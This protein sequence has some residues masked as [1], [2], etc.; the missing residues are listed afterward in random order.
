MTR[1]K[2][3]IHPILADI[4]HPKKKAAV[5]LDWKPNKINFALKS[6]KSVFK[7]AATFA[8]VGL[9]FG[10]SLYGAHLWNFK[11]EAYQSISSI[12]ENFKNAGENMMSLEPASASASLSNIDLQLKN[13]NQQASFLGMVPVLKE[14][15]EV[16]S[17][18]QELTGTIILLNND[19]AEIKGKGFSFIFNS[20]GANDGK[21]LSL[22]TDAHSNLQKLSVIATS[23]RNR[24]LKYKS[25]PDDMNSQYFELNNDLVKAADGLASVINVLGKSGENHFVVIFENPSEIRPGGGFVG[26]YADLT[27]EGGSIKNIDVNDIYYPDRFSDLKIKPPKQLQTVTT[28]WGARDA[29]W[30]FNFPTSA[31]KIIEFLEGSNIYKD[32]N[33]K[34]DGVI[35]VNVELMEDILKIVG[36]IEVPGYGLT[37]NNENFLSEV[38]REVE[39][40]RDKK[41]GQ[42]P[43]KVLSV[44]MPI[45]LE[46]L[47]GLDDARKA[48]FFDDLLARVKNKDVKFYFKDKD[49]QNIAVQSNV[50]GEV[51]DLPSNFKGDYLAVVNTNVASGKSDVFIDQAIK[52]SSR[53][54]ES[55]LVTNDLTVSRSHR[56]QDEKDWWYR[57]T[58][59]NFIKIFTPPDAVLRTMS[60]NTSKDIKAP[61]DYVKKGY[62]ID[63]D[64]SLIEDTDEYLSG[65]KT[66]VY[67]ESG[68]NVFATWFNVAAAET[69]DLSLSYDNSDKLSLAEGS[70][71]EFVLDKQS[72]VLSKFDYIL[73]A[74][75]GFKW[76]EV[77]DFIFHYRTDDMPT[78]LVID[79][80]LQKI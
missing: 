70:T 73:E 20:D 79:L 13:L 41:P 66:D 44:I 57:S 8:F 49:M 75:P 53:I 4:R 62:V 25:L 35:A 37:L 15:P 40:G 18:I 61:I 64:L 78:R 9:I 17:E 6:K 21:F 10:I 34:F 2:K 32:K 52:L 76:K 68:K 29:N 47:H 28:E 39:E 3:N 5:L 71:Y 58:N 1:P 67:K 30:F 51:F 48:E 80:T 14:V 11:N 23:L 65:F 42:N 72:G 19:M 54:D 59:K 27:M 16:I 46:R 63:K 7:K 31:G 24:V 60:G 55:G 45:I 26:S 50:A 77:N 38:Q 22:L 43:K 12:V 33:V 69:K 36:P 56:G 74:P